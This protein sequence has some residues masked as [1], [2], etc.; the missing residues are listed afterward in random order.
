MGNRRVHLQTANGSPL[1]VNGFVKLEVSVGSQFTPHDFYVVKDLNRNV[2]LGR[3]WLRANG[4]RLYYDLGALRL[5]GEY[6]SLEED[7]H[8]SSIV[9]LA[10][11]VTLKP[12]HAH[13]CWAKTRLQ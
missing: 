8:I 9:R 7:I 5:K 12:Q 3:D 1:R 2:I 10:Q 11:S 6:V 4:V 13:T